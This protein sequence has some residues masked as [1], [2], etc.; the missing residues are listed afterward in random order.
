M[1]DQQ[2]APEQ[3]D[4]D[5]SDRDSLNILPLAIIPLTDNG[6]RKARMIKNARLETVIE[7]FSND[8]SGSLQLDVEGVP[9]HFGW[10]D[11]GPRT[12]LR[13]LR[14]LKTL[15]SFDI[16]S[17]RIQ[18][19][20][21]GIEVATRDHLKLSARKTQELT[22]YMTEFTRPLIHNIFGSDEDEVRDYADLTSLFRS[23]STSN[24]LDKLN[25]MAQKMQMNLED[26]PVFLEDCGDTFL[27]MAYYRQCFDQV[28]PIVKE[29]LVAIGEMRS[30]FQLKTDRTLMQSCDMV[31]SK[32][33]WMVSNL[34]KLFDVFDQRLGD[35]WSNLS[36]ERFREVKDAIERHHTTVGG[37]LCA[38]NVKMRAWSHAFPDVEGGGLIRRGEFLMTEIKQGLDTLNKPQDRQREQEQVSPAA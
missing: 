17:L 37:L 26:L 6:L 30:S 9:K 19:R 22:D 5:D 3:I 31:E 35:M 21:L 2:T 33:K 23:A 14:N 38:L 1:A 25:Q 8:A 4:I 34:S 12:D 10:V 28:L 27:S 15:S 11:G 32:L 16:Y 7:I 36:A 29:L 24:A 18:L 20:A 13:I